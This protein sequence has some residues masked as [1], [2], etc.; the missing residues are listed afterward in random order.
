[1]KREICKLDRKHEDYF[2][3]LKHKVPTTNETVWS[4]IFPNKHRKI[5]NKALKKLSSLTKEI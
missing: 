3:W 2:Y 4:K 1:M 5:I